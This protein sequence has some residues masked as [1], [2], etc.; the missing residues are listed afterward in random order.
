MR[1]GLELLFP[2][3]RQ[4][5]RLAPMR[6]FNGLSSLHERRW[7]SSLSGRNVLAQFGQ[8]ISASLSHLA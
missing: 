8:E 1:A 2:P 4:L 7:I 6:A 5:G 3:I